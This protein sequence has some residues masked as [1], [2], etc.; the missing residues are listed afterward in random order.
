MSRQMCYVISSTIVKY[1]WI[2]LKLDLWGKEH[3]L[4]LAMPVILI[5]GQFKNYVTLNC[6]FFDPSNTTITLHHEQWQEPPDIISH[7]T[8]LHNLTTPWLKKTHTLYKISWNFNVYFHTFEFW[9]KRFESEIKAIS[10]KFD[11]RC[12][13]KMIAK[14][15]RPLIQVNLPFMFYINEIPISSQQ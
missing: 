10:M 14:M 8:L 11:F 5:W 7:L 3:L 9:M 6:P 15:L 13:Y 4:C 12:K 1:F 2:E